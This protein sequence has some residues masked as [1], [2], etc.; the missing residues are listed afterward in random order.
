MNKKFFLSL[1][2]V[3][4][5]FAGIKF[6]NNIQNE[7][8]YITNPVKIFYENFRLKLQNDIDKYLNQAK[9][10]S[11]LKEENRKLNSYFLKY[12]AL[13]DD[14]TNL[15][16]ECNVS[17][18]Q[19]Y[20]LK[21][22]RAISYVK[23]NDFSSIWIDFKDFNK[24]KIY[25]LIKDGFAAGIVAKRDSRPIAYLNS[26]KNCAYAVEI[27]KNRVPGVATGKDDK[28]MIVRFIPMYKNIKIGDEVVTSGLD[29]IFIYG[30]KVG[31][32]LKVQKR[33]GYQVAIIKTYANLLHP[34]Y[35]WVTSQKFN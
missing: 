19:K 22:V 25:G 33:A 9:T 20:N 35:F 10:I 13:K 30:I 23:L 6:Y 4:L 29:N 8:F 28:T 34:R 3:L 24:S 1:F 32:V 14:L 12:R 17:I 11:R 21:L 27:G 18:K 5:F 7:I 16:E 26:N 2:L 15:K 31:K